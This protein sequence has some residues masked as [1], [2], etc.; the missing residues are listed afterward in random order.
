MTTARLTDAQKAAYLKR[1]CHCPF[2]GSERIDGQMVEID[3]A[4]AT[5]RIE[6]LD[7]GRLWVDC[8]TLTA[9]DDAE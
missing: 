1:P 2:C 5:Q 7:C 9:V 6:C 3:E 4:G 8:Y